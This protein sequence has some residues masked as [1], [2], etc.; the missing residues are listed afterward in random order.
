V[1]IADALSVPV[2]LLFMPAIDET[3]VTCPIASQIVWKILT[4][5]PGDCEFICEWIATRYL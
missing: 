4:L 3:L 5:P 2:Y 1:L